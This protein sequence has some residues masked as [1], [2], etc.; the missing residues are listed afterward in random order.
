[1]VRHPLVAAIIRAYDRKAQ[2]NG[3]GRPPS[4]EG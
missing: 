2:N 3:G 1:V 4:S